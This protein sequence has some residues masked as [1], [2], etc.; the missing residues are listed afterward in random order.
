MDER[1]TE[2][3]LLM[4]T[5]FSESSDRA[6]EEAVR[7]AELLS[8][9]LDIAHICHRPAFTREGEM[10]SV[11]RAADCLEALRA[12]VALTVPADAHLRTGDPVSGLLGV[13]HDLQPALV[14]VGSHGRSAV[15][16]ALLGGVTT[17]LCHQ[18]PVAVLVVPAPG[19]AALVDRPGESQGAPD[20]S[21]SIAWSCPGCGHIR[22]AM[23]SEKTCSRCGRHPAI[24]DSAPVSWAPADA[25]ERAVGESVFDEPTGQQTSDTME[26]FQSSPPG[27]EGY[28]VNPELRVRY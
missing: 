26:L 2:M 23:A 21:R 12:R 9:R 3:T 1:K 16:R 18:S 7:L 24:W 19:L 14:I 25:L 17:R 11:M 22:G 20:A 10:M 6:L 4:G 8:A 5:D 28:D 15:T 13:I 27:T